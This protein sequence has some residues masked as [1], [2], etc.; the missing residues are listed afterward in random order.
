MMETKE[1]IEFPTE[2][3]RPRLASWVLVGLGPLY[4]G[5]AIVG[6]SSVCR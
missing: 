2:E 6:C 5:L 3:K 4:A 1:E